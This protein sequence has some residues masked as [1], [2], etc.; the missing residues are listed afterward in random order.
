MNTK[1]ADLPDNTYKMLRKHFG[2]YHKDGRPK[3]PGYRGPKP[4]E[5]KPVITGRK[6]KTFKE[7]YTEAMN[8]IQSLRDKG[9]RTRTMF[10]RGGRYMKIEPIPKPYVGDEKAQVKTQT[11]V[12]TA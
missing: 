3:P 5:I 11:K 12:K 6:M 1:E 9:Y 4:N 10:G 2:D 8:V 7:F